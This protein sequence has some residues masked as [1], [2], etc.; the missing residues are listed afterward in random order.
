MKTLPNDIV[1][2]PR[3][4][5]ELK[6]HKNN[7]LHF[8]EETKKGNFLVNCVDEYV[9]I[10]FRKEY[11][12]FWSPQLHLEIHEKETDL[13]TLYGQFG[14]NPSLWTF[15]MF[16]HFGIAT[17]FITFGIWTY[18]NWSL[19]KPYGIQIGILILMVLIW[20][21]LYIFGRL[22]RSKGKPQMVELYHFMEETLNHL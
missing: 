15:F 5:I 11:T 16:L 7:V 6:S 17:I 20:I 9:F 13:S 14:P 8:F 21:S 10:K 18:S 4:E 1:L 2:R 3:F 19:G 22:G 12:H